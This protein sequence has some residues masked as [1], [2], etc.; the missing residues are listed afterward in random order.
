MGKQEQDNRFAKFGTVSF[1]GL[2]QVNDFIDHLEKG[3]LMGTR[4]KDCGKL[5]FPPRAHCDV[6][7]TANMEW[8]EV[9]GAGRLV[10]FSTL[11]YAPTGF[12]DDL[13]YT[14]ALLDYGNFK[15][16]GRIDRAVALDKIEVGM[17]M[18]AKTGHTGNGQLT[19]V[20]T[21]A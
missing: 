7:R 5:F 11:K 20:F 4:C 19:Y 1:A 14:I 17:A 6:C 12:Q 2:T 16:F 18:Q 21:A 8:F 15:I 10:S 9:S 3:T 13:P